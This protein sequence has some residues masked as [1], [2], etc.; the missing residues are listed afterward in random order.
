M[1]RFNLCYSSCCCCYCS[2]SP[3]ARLASPTMSRQSASRTY[4]VPPRPLI[5]V[6]AASSR[7]PRARYTGRPVQHSS[8]SALISTRSTSFRG[9]SDLALVLDLHM[10][11]MLHGQGSRVLS[12]SSPSRYATAAGANP[13][14]ARHVVLPRT[15]FDMEKP[16]T[17]PLQDRL[18][19]A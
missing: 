8:L 9:C 5:P 3:L 17:V 13:A 4:Q 6:L 19:T 11:R 2:L 10:M 12:S 15:A 1:V 18:S 14:S 16:T 7:P